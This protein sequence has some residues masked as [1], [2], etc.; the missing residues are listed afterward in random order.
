MSCDLTA[1]YTKPCADN[2]GG[3]DYIQV[4]EL[5]NV[6][7]FTENA[8]EVTGI[9]IASGKRMWRWD[10]ERELSSATATLTRSRD[11]GTLFSAQ[12]LNIVLNDNTKA[13]RNQLLLMGKNDL[14][15][16]VKHTNGDFELFGANNGLTMVT[17]QHATG[18]T[19]SDRN[20]NVV[21]FMGMEKFSPY[22]VA[23]GIIAGLLVVAS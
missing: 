3:I 1:G 15:V 23:A 9:N 5:A 8:G 4:I 12:G 20:G 2:V 22:K 6:T 14:F 7:G 11:N 18:T 17:A 10:L 21:E 19:K 13:T 16:I